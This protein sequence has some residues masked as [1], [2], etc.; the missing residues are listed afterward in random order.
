VYIAAFVSELVR[1]GDHFGAAL[2]AAA[3]ASIIIEKSG[4]AVKARMPTD[5]EVRRR[6][7]SV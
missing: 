3:A 4:G 5:V 7:V 6:L 2:F 1:S